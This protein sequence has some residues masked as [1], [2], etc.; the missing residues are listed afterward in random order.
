[1]TRELHV[2][3]TLPSHRQKALKN[4]QV[5]H[6]T[7][8]PLNAP[9][10]WHASQD[11]LH[12]RS[13]DM[14]ASTC[15]LDKRAFLALDDIVSYQL[16]SSSRYV[17][18][19]FSVISVSRFLAIYFSSTL[20]LVPQLRPLRRHPGHLR[21]P[22]STSMQS[23]IARNQGSLLVGGFVATGLS[24]VVAVQ[25]VIYFKVYQTDPNFVKA[26]VAL[27]WALDFTHSILSCAA[28]WEYLIAQ[29]GHPELIDVIPM[30]LSLT[31]VFTAILT[32]FVHMFFVHRIWLLSQKNYYL[33]IPFLML[34]TARLGAAAATCNE[35]IVLKSLSAY[36]SRFGWLFTMGL[37][38]S[39]LVDILITLSMF[40][41]LRSSRSRSLSLNHVI[42][43]LILYTFEIGSLTCAGTIISLI[44]WL[45]LER[46]LVFMGLHVLIAKLYATSLLASLNSRNELRR[47]RQ[48]S[49]EVMNL[50]LDGSRRRDT[51]Q[52]SNQF[53]S[54][55]VQLQRVHINVEK[56]VTYDAGDGPR[57]PVSIKK[58]PPSPA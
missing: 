53:D 1:M 34:V 14:H 57:S 9:G 18:V 7:T 11:L 55:D 5:L 45:A 42:D 44:T 15:D 48:T 51:L 52:L 26:L 56:S 23:E 37:T 16:F 13:W 36:K 32:F 12:I 20:L 40:I 2:S 29:Y 54:S 21:E 19:C 39:S 24:G 30:E 43:S 41:M 28:I 10:A 58:S 38:L 31:I 4:G 6:A 25:T 49:H 33:A 3:L 46:S 22:A 35:M 8:I 27:I 47:S 17:E 50:D